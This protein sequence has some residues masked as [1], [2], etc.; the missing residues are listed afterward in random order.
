[1]NRQGWLWHDTQI[2]PAC[3]LKV[4]TS[5]SGVRTVG[6]CLVVRTGSAPPSSMLGSTTRYHHEVPPLPSAQRQQ[7]VPTCCPPASI[8]HPSSIVQAPLP[9]THVPL[10]EGAR[11]GVLE[12]SS[13]DQSGPVPIQVAAGATG[14]SKLAPAAGLQ[15][16]SCASF[17]SPARMSST[18]RPPTFYSHN[19]RTSSFF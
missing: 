18:L 6:S 12:Q 10:V 3:L 13:C 8:S 4:D 11:V 2:V 5:Q 9:A 1:M 14:A 15:D 19:H 7:T 17:I 16:R